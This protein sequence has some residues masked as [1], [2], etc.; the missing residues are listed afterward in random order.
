[1]PAVAV[2]KRRKTVDRYRS[3]FLGNTRSGTA[4]EPL[5]DRVRVFLEKITRTGRL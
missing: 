1:V 2:S 5:S 3:D 4:G